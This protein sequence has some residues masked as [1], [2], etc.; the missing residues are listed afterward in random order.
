MELPCDVL[1]HNSLIGLK[2]TAGT[3]VRIN[4]AGYYEVDLT[5]GDKTH[6]VM[7]PIADTVVIEREPQPAGIEAD[8]EIER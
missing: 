6:R 4:E 8:F 7:L 2:G 5:F 3:L 1:L